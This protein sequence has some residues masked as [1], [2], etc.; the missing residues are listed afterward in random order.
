M[1]HRRTPVSSDTAGCAFLRPFSEKNNLNKKVCANDNTLCSSAGTRRGGRT[2]AGRNPES[3]ADPEARRQSADP[4][5]RDKKSGSRRGSA[6]KNRRI[7]QGE[8]VQNPDRLAAFYFTS[9]NMRETRRIG[10]AE[11]P[12]G[13]NRDH[14]VRVARTAAGWPLALRGRI[15]SGGG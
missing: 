4:Q 5:R 1:A 15:R 14:G 9:G 13:R 3:M 12:A 8:G 2:L 11:T 6:E 10:A 7:P